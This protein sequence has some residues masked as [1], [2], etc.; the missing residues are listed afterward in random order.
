MATSTLNVKFD[1]GALYVTRGA[2]KKL[3]HV[4]ILRGLFRHIEGDFG[5]LCEEDKLV[6]LDAIE[7]GYRILSAYHTADGTKFWIITEADRS[8]TTILLPEEY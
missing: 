7:N 5:D 1:Y 8:A 2:S 6:N 3:S 4:D